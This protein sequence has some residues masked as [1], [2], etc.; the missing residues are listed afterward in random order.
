[1]MLIEEFICKTNQAKNQ[2]EVFD[3]FIQ[4]LSTLGYNRVLYSLLTDH[5][6]I[7][8]KAGH[9]IVNNYPEDW[10]TYYNQNNYIIADPVVKNAYCDPAAFTWKNLIKTKNLSKIEK[11]IM[12]ESN[13]AKLLDGVGVAIYGVN[14]EISGVGLASSTGGIQH[15]KNTLSIIRLIV[16]QF[17]FTYTE[18]E[19]TKPIE[20]F[21]ALTPR[22]REILLWGA[23]GKTIPVMASILGISENTIN[24]HLKNIHYKLNVTDRTQAVVKAI[25][26]GLI[27]PTRVSHSGNNSKQSFDRAYLPA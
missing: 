19:K 7:N 2:Q 26:L 18:F 11:K 24:F 22:E 21:I 8:R 20:K 14:A 10:L 23:E 13:E 25:Y 27:N 6:S 16:N 5:Q 17:H 4:T 3:I 15:D 1:M 12:A 9:G